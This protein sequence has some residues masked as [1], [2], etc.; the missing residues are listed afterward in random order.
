L[1]YNGAN[2]GKLIN[3]RIEGINTSSSLRIP[4]RK[5]R[6]L[7]LADSYY[8]WKKDGLKKWPFRIV[9]ADQSLMVMAGVWEEWE[10]SGKKI[11]SFSIITKP[12]AGAAADVSDRM[13]LILKSSALQDLW[14]DEVNLDDV[15]Q[16][17]REVELGELRCYPISQKVDIVGYSS[18]ELHEE[19]AS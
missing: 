10:K 4:I 5:R 7:V 9:N 14:L 11:R 8:A 1:H 17:V 19:L 13:P 15:F 2:N 16:I 3:A 12:A 18:D 6:C